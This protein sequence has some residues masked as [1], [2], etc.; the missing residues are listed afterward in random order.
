MTAARA[1]MRNRF[2]REKGRRIAVPQGE[3]PDARGNRE[4]GVLCGSPA[5]VAEK[6]AE[7]A[8]LGVGGIIA[9]FRLGP[10]PHEVAAASLELFLRHVAPQFR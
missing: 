5:T 4:H 2:W 9:T 6:I 8:A 10:M 1:E 3:L 7:I